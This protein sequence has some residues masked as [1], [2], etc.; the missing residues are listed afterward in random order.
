MI[1]VN[2]TVEVASDPR[3]VWSL[4]SDPRAVVECVSGATLGERHEDGSYDAGVT[5]KFGPAKVA[6]RA[7]VE[8]EY[9]HPTM[10]G[11][12]ISRGK[13]NQGGARFNTTM[14]FGV[15]EREGESGSVIP[16]QANVEISGRLASLIETGATMVVKR[17]TKEFSEQLALRCTGVGTA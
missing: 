9:D 11:K 7:K 14:H 6:F 12:V 1:E 17:M 4:L 10:S 15:R 8:I 13:D 2:E 3:T 5:V 16:I